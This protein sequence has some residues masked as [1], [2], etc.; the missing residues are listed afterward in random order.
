LI[1]FEHPHITDI[2]ITILSRYFENI[3]HGKF[4]AILI[5][6]IRGVCLHIGSTGK[7]PMIAM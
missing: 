1:L 3:E 4:Q 2:Y 5:H 6:K 7:Y